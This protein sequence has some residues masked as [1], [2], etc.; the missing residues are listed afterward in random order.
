M[1][2]IIGCTNIGEDNDSGLRTLAFT[3]DR[4]FVQCKWRRTEKCC[5][6]VLVL[7]KDCIVIDPPLGLT[8][9]TD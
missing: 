3:P 6:G 9:S 1:S 7:V 5:S 4:R 8:W 2:A